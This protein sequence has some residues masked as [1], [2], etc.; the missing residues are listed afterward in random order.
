M[1][2]TEVVPPN[3]DDTVKIELQSIDKIGDNADFDSDDELMESDPDYLLTI[4]QLMEQNDLALHQR[5][6]VAT[7]ILGHLSTTFRLWYMFGGIMRIHHGSWLV[8]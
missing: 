1:R 6:L 5:D 3:A 2:V 4:E 8:I 7:S